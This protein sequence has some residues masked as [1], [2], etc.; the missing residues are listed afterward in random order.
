[1][2]F[3]VSLSLILT[4]YYLNT[5]HLTIL[6]SL[7]SIPFLYIDSVFKSSE[8]LFSYVYKGPVN[9]YLPQWILQD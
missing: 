4:T 2:L 1:M 9:L 7:W 8:Y 6:D 5:L 3:C